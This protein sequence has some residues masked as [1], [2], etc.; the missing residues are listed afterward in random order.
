MPDLP[1]NI[2]AVLGRTRHR[3]A[4]PSGADLRRSDLVACGVRPARAPG[5]GGARR[6]G[7]RL[8]RPCRDR[9]VGY[10]RGRRADVRPGAAWGDPAA[11]GPT[12]GAQRRRTRWRAGSGRRACWRPMRGRCGRRRCWRSTP[13][14]ADRIDAAP[15]TAPIARRPDLPL[16]VSLSSGT[17]GRP[18]GPAVTH[19][20]MIHRF[21]QSDGF[22]DLR[23]VRP[24][25]HGDAALFRRRPDL[26]PCPS[27]TSAGRW[28]CSRRPT[29]RRISRPASCATGRRPCFLVPTLLRRMLQLPDTEKAA[30]RALR[31]LVSSG[32]PLFPPERAAVRREL[33][34]AFFEYYASTEGGGITVLPPQDQEAHPESVGPP[35]VSGSRWRSS[36]RTTARC[37]RARSAGCATAG[38]A[39][40]RPSS[41]IPRP[42]PAHSG[43]A[44]SI[45]ATSG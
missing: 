13:A 7:D 33:N 27:S 3:P 18:R 43:T 4:V 22:P 40:P 24:V 26:H 2:A 39:W 34:P 23:L 12:A 32:A 44:G 6:R 10:G 1:P 42:M 19:A 5:G 21:R 15:D 11:D 41:A 30:F 8:R 28:C 9:A 45:P 20:Q 36:T 14:F 25:R 17:T 35:R 38:R 16:L 29:R 37:R 31:L